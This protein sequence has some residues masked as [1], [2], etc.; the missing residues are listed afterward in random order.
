MKEYHIFDERFIPFKQVL[1]LLIRI[2]NKSFFCFNKILFNKARII[3]I[4]GSDGS[5][6]TTLV[7]DILGIYKPYFPCSKAHLGKP[8]SGNK[9]FNKIFFKKYGFNKKNNNQVN[10]KIFKSSLRTTFLSLFDY[11]LLIFKY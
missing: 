11:F 5:G 6:K 4:Y 8:F 2:S 9:I 10:N 1:S 7:N 3:T